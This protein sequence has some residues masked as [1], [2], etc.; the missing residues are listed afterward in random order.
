MIKQDICHSLISSLT[1]SEKRYIRLFAGMSGKDKKY[2][3]VFNILEKMPVYDR[4]LFR[5]KALKYL[6]SGRI[7]YT[8]HYLIQLILRALRSYHSERTDLIGPSITDLEIL[9][10]K[11]LPAQFLSISDKLKQDMLAQDTLAEY[12]M[13]TR[14]E[15]RFIGNLQMTDRFIDYMEGGF[16]RDMRIIDAFKYGL[17]MIAK[18]NELNLVEAKYRFNEPEIFRER[19]L[20]ITDD[21][22]FDGLFDKLPTKARMTWFNFFAQYYG[23]LNRVEEAYQTSTAQLDYIAANELTMAQIGLF[24]YPAMLLTHINNSRRM[25]R[26]EESLAYCKT[27]YETLHTEAYLHA[28]ALRDQFLVVYADA[29]MQNLVFAGKYAE[30]IAFHA[31]FTP[32]LVRL[33][34]I[35]GPN[36]HI[37]T[38]YYL[39]AA[40]F[41]IRQFDAAL[42]ALLPIPAW[43]KLTPFAYQA[44]PS[45]VLFVLC[46]I[47]LGNDAFVAHHLRSFTRYFVKANVERATIQIITRLCRDMMRFRH[48]ARGFRRMLPKWEAQVSHLLADPMSGEFILHC[49]LREWLDMRGATFE[50]G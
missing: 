43:E 20:R 41:G 17:F 36:L 6:P 29:M 45:R 9:T 42:D 50:A 31:D 14:L 4:V 1:P 11:G 16:T 13:I 21:A 12:I 47:E 23:L 33:A 39:A 22:Q 27:L 34:T 10:E 46:H 15:L 48:S 18:Y 8:K 30:C 5:K 32:E 25:Q 49:R 44:Y 2:I 7:A 3:P 40:H 19:L 24:N 38:N 26:L 35:G 37:A 28:P